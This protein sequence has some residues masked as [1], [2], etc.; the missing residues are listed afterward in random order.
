M[1]MR[2]IAKKM[3]RAMVEPPEKGERA[4]LN[5]NHSAR[6]KPTF[7]RSG[8]W[9]AGWLLLVEEGERREM[10]RVSAHR[11]LL[12][13]ENPAALPL[14]DAIIEKA[15]RDTGLPATMA[16]IERIPQLDD[17]SPEVISALTRV[18]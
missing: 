18:C 11:K 17:L 4:S 1:P 15:L 14:Q 7:F 16:L 12:E 6:L 3:C 13:Q 9:A 8:P 10:T 2:V 5:P